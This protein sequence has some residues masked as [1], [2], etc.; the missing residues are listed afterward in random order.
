MLATAAKAMQVLA[1]DCIMCLGYEERVGF[2][3][4]LGVF[5]SISFVESE[6]WWGKQ[7]MRCGN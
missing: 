5:P 1:I 7:V 2:G 3:G 4:H 6:L